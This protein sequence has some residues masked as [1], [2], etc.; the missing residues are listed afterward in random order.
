MVKLLYHEPVGKA[1]E[2]GH[3]EKERARMTQGS[4]FV[5]G[6]EGL[7]PTDWTVGPWSP[8]TLPGSV[9]A[10]LLIRALER[11]E[12]APTKAFFGTCEQTLVFERREP[13]P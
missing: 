3:V 4:L 8:E 5:A 13:A 10:G 6:V 9:Y 2:S 1:G 7:E 11:S 12:G